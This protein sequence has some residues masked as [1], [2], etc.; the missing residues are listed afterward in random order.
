MTDFAN[1]ALKNRPEVP[2]TETDTL[3]PENMTWVDYT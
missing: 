3:D 2:D 1:E